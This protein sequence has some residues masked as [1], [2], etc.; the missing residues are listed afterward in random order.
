MLLSPFLEY[1]L[2]HIL[3]LA[4]HVLP[5]LLPSAAVESTW[6]LCRAPE[7]SCYESN[8]L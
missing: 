2:G 3:G 5:P 1:F 4:Q 8:D 6:R 7:E